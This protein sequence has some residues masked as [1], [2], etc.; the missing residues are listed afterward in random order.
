VEGQPELSTHEDYIAHSSITTAS[1][2]SFGLTVGGILAV[3][4][5][6]RWWWVGALSW[7]MTAFLVIGI[8]L[9]LAGL[10]RPVILAPLN[11][12]WTKLGLLMFHVVNPVVMLLLFIITI[13]PAG[14]V[15]KLLENGLGVDRR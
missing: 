9:L 15:L 7:L 12:G 2:R 8:A 1:D 4:A 14:E 10:L 5:L 6:V 11:K 3:I 13:I